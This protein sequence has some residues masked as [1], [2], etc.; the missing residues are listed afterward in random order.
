MWVLAFRNFN[1]SQQNTTSAVEGYHG[2]LKQLDLKSARKRLV[3]R[4]LDWLIQILLSET[5]QRYRIRQ[6][7]KRQG[8]VRNS[9]AE[10]AVRVSILAAQK[11][12]SARVRVLDSATGR[13]DVSSPTHIGYMVD[14][15]LTAHPMCSCPPGLGGAICKHI[16][17]V[18]V[19]LGKGETDILLAWGVLRGS[20]SGDRMIAAWMAAAAAPAAEP[21]G[22][23]PAVGG[24]QA[25]SDASLGQRQCGGT[26]RQLTLTGDG[27]SAPVRTAADYDAS[28][29]ACIQHVK[30]TLI[31]Q[32]VST[33][34]FAAGLAAVLQSRVS[35]V[36][37]R[38]EVFGGSRAPVLPLPA[39]PSAPAGM[40]RL[41]L[42]SFVENRGASR[43]RSQ[44]SSQ[45]RTAVA[46]Q[47][48]QAA[49]NGAGAKR[50]LPIVP[51]EPA[52]QPRARRP[53]S[54]A[55]LVDKRFPRAGHS[56]GLPLQEAPPRASGLL[57][58]AAQQQSVA[59][60]QH[61]QPVPSWD[62]SDLDFVM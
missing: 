57:Q 9:K 30:A 36:S 45:P 41:R 56:Q 33:R 51:L 44:T 32:P 24:E 40:S 62:F 53:R 58:Q 25:G 17:K 3:S 29:D 50:P 21:G 60:S 22:T 61:Q 31:G 15:A 34:E 13:A 4:R 52:R 39:N 46:V 37:A 10:A 47:V 26:Q 49:T 23:V 6:L 28:F 27:S 48:L 18:M 2:A 7:L 43:H 59:S 54:L 19:V 35:T 14:G 38:A 55:E 20:D 1:Y 5:E 16:V 11:V 12:D 8:Y 42:P